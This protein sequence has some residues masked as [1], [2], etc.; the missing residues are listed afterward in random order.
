MEMS[1]QLQNVFKFMDTNGD[2]KISPLELKQFV[3]SLGDEN[4]MSAAE[5]AEGMVR[6][7]DCDGDGFVSLDEFMRV[8]RKY[9][10]SECRKMIERVDRDGDGFVNFQDFKIMMS[11]GYNMLV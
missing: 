6:E 1:S 7:M 10:I 11:A 8:M 9:W 4:S 5:L 2:G 3:S